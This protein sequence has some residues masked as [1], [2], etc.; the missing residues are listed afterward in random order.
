MLSLVGLLEHKIKENRYDVISKSMLPNLTIVNNY[1]C[2]SSGRIL[3][4]WD[5]L[6]LSLKVLAMSTQSIHFEAL[7]LD[8]SCKF[9][10][11]FIYGSN[12]YV[13]R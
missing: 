13:D 7:V 11:S 8:G 10:A 4:G 9:R 12:S 5:P 6:V 1:P 3:V 2:A